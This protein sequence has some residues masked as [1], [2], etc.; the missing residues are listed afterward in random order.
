M[1]FPLTTIRGKLI[2]STTMVNTL[3]RRAPFSGNIQE[4]LTALDS[5]RVNIVAH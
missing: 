1:A 2:M 3:L 5:Y 4:L